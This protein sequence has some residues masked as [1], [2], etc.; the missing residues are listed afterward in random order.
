MTA[1]AQREIVA[2]FALHNLNFF[3]LF[4]HLKGTLPQSPHS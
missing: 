1:T 2:P 3:V 4:I